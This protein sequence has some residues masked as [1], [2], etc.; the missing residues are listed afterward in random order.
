[1]KIGIYTENFVGFKGK[2]L[3]SGAELVLFELCNALMKRGHDLTVFQV[4]K[5]DDEFFFKGIKVIQV[6]IPEMRLLNKMG[7][8]TRFHLYGILINRYIDKKNF[9]KI[10]FHYFFS[11]F[12]RVDKNFTGMSHGIEWDDPDQYSPNL[13]SI[14]DRFS[15]FLMK[16]I[17]KYNIKR[18]NAVVANDY[19]FLKFVESNFPKYRNKVYYIPNYVDTDLFRPRTEHDEN[20]RN[21]Y[22]NHFLILIPKFITK[23]RGQELFIE[24]MSK[25]NQEQLGRIKLLL[26]G[27]IDEQSKYHKY[28]NTIIKEHKLE[29]NIEFLGYKDHFSELPAM[30]NS[31]DLVAVPSYCREGTSLSVLEGMASKKPVLCTNIGALPELVYDNYTGFISK[32]NSTD[33]AIKISEIINMPKSELDNI[34]SRG[35]EYCVNNFNKNKWSKSW[36]DF[37]ER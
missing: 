29:G 5:A 23:A 1:M 3:F 30:I 20:L 34:A 13:R 33:L 9:D 10:H 26:L 12:P 32:P 18:M 27:H 17:A 37:F 28:I 21:L 2:E 24:A 22:P 11:A 36:V 7:I 19:N 25:L 15:N 14:R 31:V 8:T 16:K 4:G 35:H 6:K